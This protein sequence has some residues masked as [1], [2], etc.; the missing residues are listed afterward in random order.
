MTTFDVNSYFQPIQ[1]ANALRA[2]ERAPQMGGYPNSLMTRRQSPGYPQGDM[3]SYVR[4]GLAQRGLPDHIAEAFV[5]NF[6]DESNLNPGINEIAPIVPGSR[7][8]FGLSQWT[9][10]RRRQLEAFARQRGADIADPDLQMDF[11]IHELYGTEKSAARHIM[12]SQN[13]GE[14]AA[15][16]VNKFLRPAESHRARR[17]RRYLSRYSGA[18][19]AP[20]QSFTSLPPVYSQ[21]YS[22]FFS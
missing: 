9:G 20:Q 3:A 11:L 10:P 13:T 22:L 19:A 6:K 18:S 8:G 4:A 7:G 2:M 14:A 17:E 21:I 5:L 16:I 12:N 15:A 1:Q